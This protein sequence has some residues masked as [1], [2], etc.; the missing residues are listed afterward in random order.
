MREAQLR[1]H[2]AELYPRIRA[3]EWRSAATLADQ[4][5]A[6][7]LLNE[8]ATAVRGRVLPELHFEFRGGT[9]TGGQREG[10]RL[11]KE[12]AL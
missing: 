1:P 3:G 9:R 10:L 2:Y 12:G 5:L 6:G 8:V 11:Q 7:Q 4:V